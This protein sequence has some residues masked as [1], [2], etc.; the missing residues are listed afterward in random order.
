MK[1]R[2]RP[3]LKELY[4][5]HAGKG[6]TYDPKWETFEGF[7]EDMKEGYSDELSLDRIFGDKNYTKDNCRWTN[8]SVQ[9]Y[10]KGIDP[11]NTSGKTGVSFYS[12]QQMWSAEIHCNGKHIRLGMFSNFE[13]AV[14]AREA[15][16]IKY[17][18]WNKDD[19]YNG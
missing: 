16:E 10:N 14:K 6:I 13:D 8:L 18:G 2:C 17:Y 15:A 11:N 9:G 19:R 1:R 4:P 5:Y 12:S 3:D 7:Y